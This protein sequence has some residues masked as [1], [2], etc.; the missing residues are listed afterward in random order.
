M[1]KIV[2]ALGALGLVGLSFVVAFGFEYFNQTNLFAVA[3]GLLLAAGA[4]VEIA[5]LYN[6]KD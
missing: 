3:V 5:V 6:N 4:V 1:V 2:I